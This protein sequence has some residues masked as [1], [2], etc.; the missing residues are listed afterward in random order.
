MGIAGALADEEYRNIVAN[1]SA[2]PMFLIPVPRGEG[3]INLIWQ[4]QGNVFIYKTL[5]SF[6]NGS[7]DVDL[8]VTLFDEL[9]DS[10]QIALLH[11]EIQTRLLTKE[12]AARVVRYTRAAY[13][14]QSFFAWVKKFN[15]SPRDFDYEQFMSE[16]KP[17]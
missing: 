10:H 7:S 4:A 14:D 17:L 1:A 15:Q 8:G 3:Y 11:A 16:C 2:C 5:E 9:M 12:D 13:A 6:Q